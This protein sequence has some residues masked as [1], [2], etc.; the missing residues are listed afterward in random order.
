VGSSNEPS[1]GPSFVLPWTQRDDPLV[2]ASKPNQEA[3]PS[4][5]KQVTSLLSPVEESARSV[6]SKPPQEKETL[7]NNVPRV[8][9]FGDTVF[10]A[11]ELAFQQGGAE[12]VAS[13]THDSSMALPPKVTIAQL[14]SPEAPLE[15]T[16]ESD[17]EFAPGTFA[18]SR[19]SAGGGRPP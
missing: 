18:F 19:R 10:Q 15:A 8:L 16:L 3:H 14:P 1:G 4:P 13:T 9:A 17:T 6:A 2:A 12:R 11:I 7:A 5:E